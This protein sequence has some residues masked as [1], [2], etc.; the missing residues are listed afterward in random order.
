LKKSSFNLPPLSTL[1]IPDLHIYKD[2]KGKKTDFLL[3]VVLYPSLFLETKLMRK[4][5]DFFCPRKT[6]LS[7]MDAFLIDPLKK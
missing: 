7:Q 4:N 3:F 5:P 6:L 1:P 2:F